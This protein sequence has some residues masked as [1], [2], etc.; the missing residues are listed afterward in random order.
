MAMTPSNTNDPNPYQTPRS[1]EGSTPPP[2]RRR[3]PWVLV[4]LGGSLMAVATAAPVVA[5][6]WTFEAVAESPATPS[7]AELAADVQVAGLVTVAAV[8]AGLLGLVTAIVG[9]LLLLVGPKA[10]GGKGARA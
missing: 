4:V 7:P 6:T 5:F 3:W 1:V 8:G 10:P 9:V 2:R